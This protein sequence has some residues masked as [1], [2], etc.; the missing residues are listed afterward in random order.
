MNEYLIS[1]VILVCLVFP[2]VQGAPSSL[3]Q[4]QVEGGENVSI[5]NVSESFGY[6]P[7]SP[8]T[9]PEPYQIALTDNGGNVLVSDNFSITRVISA[10]PTN[11]SCEQTERGYRCENTVRVREELTVTESLDMPFRATQLELYHDGELEDT[12]DIR[13]YNVRCGDGLCSSVEEG[14]CPADCGSSGSSD[15]TSD[16]STDSTS[17]VLWIVGASVIGVILLASLLKYG[18]KE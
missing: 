7:S 9:P 2:V 14:R 5:K 6:A 12:R 13:R 1:G 18:Q 3:L 15:S 16:Q 17:Y 4:V 8:S 11:E 10:A